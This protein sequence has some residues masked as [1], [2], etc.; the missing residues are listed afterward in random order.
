MKSRRRTPYLLFPY[1]RDAR[2]VMRLIPAADMARRF[3]R[4]WAHL[5]RWEANL[6]NRESGK[7]DRDDDWWGYVYLKNMAK[8]RLGQVNRTSVL[9]ST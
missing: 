5:G 8:A 1:E 6:R 9:W 4:A 2:D 3:P 7:M